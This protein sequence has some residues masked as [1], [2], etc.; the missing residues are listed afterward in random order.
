M[1]QARFC[2][3][4]VLCTVL[5]TLAQQG[6]VIVTGL[7]Q[8][9]DIAFD[10]SEPTRC[11]I[12]EQGGTIRVVED[13]VVR[14]EPFYSVDRANFTN[15]GWEQGLLGI[16][17]DPDFANNRRFY[18]NYTGRRGTTH[19]S[20]VTA[21]DATHATPERE[22]VL[23][24]IDQ[25]YENHNGGC[26]RFGPDGMLYIGMGDGGAGGDPHGHGQRLD[27]L[28]GKLLRIDVTGEPEEGRKY[29]VPKDNPFVGNPEVRPEIWA[30][31]LRNPW[32]FEFDSKGRV[33]I[34]DVGQ[35][36]FEWIHL[37][38]EGSTGGEN[39]GWNV[40]E[41]AEKFGGGSIP[42]GFESVRPVWVYSQRSNGGNGSVTGGF[43][44]EGEAIPALAGRYIYA[45]FMS[46]RTWSFKLG[47]TGSADDV[48]ELTPRFE[49]VFEERG[50]D[51]AI[52]GFG[53]D[54]EGELYILDHKA[55]RLIK[56][57]P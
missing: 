28:L 43:F 54:A 1:I 31:G 8:P 42:E 13:G 19:I 49:D 44:Y 14:A 57:V 2:C 33:W 41:G 53:R 35:N 51:L 37:Q 6:R 30:Y 47:A 32:K 25:P 36:K 5:P 17:L 3:C 21:T 45:D 39:Y 26:I 55:G 40:L 38:P 7:K 16:A 34:G 9:V 18:I 27:S 23:L 11:F 56:I 46:G 24:T 50:R 4:V 15:R 22:E 52:S 48:I 29:S 20:R 10:P 12:V